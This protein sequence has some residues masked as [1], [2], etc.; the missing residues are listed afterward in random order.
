MNKHWINK[1]LI[2]KHWISLGIAIRNG[3][4]FYRYRTYQRILEIHLFLLHIRFGYLVEKV[5][6]DE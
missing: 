4:D 1:I 2:D 6:S 3:E 5:E